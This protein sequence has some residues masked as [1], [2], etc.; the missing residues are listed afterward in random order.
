MTERLLSAEP[1]EP[2]KANLVRRQGKVPAVV[3]GRTL[4]SRAITVDGR[5]LQLIM[6]KGRN[7]LLV[8]TCDGSENT[9]MIADVQRHPVRGNVLHVDFHAVALDELVRARVPV[10]VVGEDSVSAGGGIV[11]HQLHAIEVRCL[12]GNLPVR[13]TIDVTGL[14]VG[15]HVS[16]SQVSLPAEVRLLTD[17]SEIV[18]TVVA[19]KI[20]EEPVKE[21]APAAEE[22]E[23]K[24]EEA[25]AAEEQPA[26]AQPPK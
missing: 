2:G 11:Q 7:R 18:I 23:A 19:P 5:Q 6:A 3:Y 17:P 22:A 14:H 20:L 25:P 13:V 12:P 10:S 4:P 9:V 24:P 16:A 1:R 26:K 15:E 21:A 8:L